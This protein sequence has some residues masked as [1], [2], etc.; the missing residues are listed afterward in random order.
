[1]LLHPSEEVND[2]VLPYILVFK[3]CQAYMVNIETMFINKFHEKEPPVVFHK[4]HWSKILGAILGMKTIYR[5]KH[6]IKI[7]N[8]KQQAGQ[9][10]Y[11]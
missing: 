11:C 8:T 1:M 6:N 10:I 3:S 4:E 7:I 2:K 9:W 5:R